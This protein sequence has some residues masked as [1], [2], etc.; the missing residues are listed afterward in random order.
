MKKTLIAFVFIF[1]FLLYFFTARL[2]A[3]S[4]V[5]LQNSEPNISLDFQDVGLKDALKVFSMQSGLNFIASEGVQERKITLYL[6]NVP[7]KKA[8]D[9]LFKANNLSYDLDTDSNIFIVKDWGKLTTETVTRVFYL[10][11]ATVSS[12]SLKEEMYNQ[13]NKSTDFST[14]SSSSSSS[15]STSSTGGSGKW[16]V[17]ENSGITEAIKKLLSASGSVIEDFRTNSLIVTDTPD[18]MAVVEKV[19]ASL[20]IIVPQV[21]LE[22]EMLDVSKNVVDQLGFDFGS[23][24][25]T[26]IVTGATASMGF[27]YAGLSKIFNTGDGQLSI[28]P[29]GTGGSPYSVTLDYLRTQ[30]DTKFLARPKLFTLNNE[31]AEIRI[32]SN[33]SIGIKTTVTSATSTTSAEAERTQTGIILRVTPQ[34]NMDTGEITMFV[35]PKVAEAVAGNTL[36][37]GSEDF[38]FRDPEERSTKSIVRVKDGETVVLGG[39]I[40]NEITA[41]SS[42]LP[43]LGDIPIIGM[44]FRHKGGSADKNKQRELLVFITPHIVKDKPEAKLAKIKNIE[45]P[46]REQNAVNHSNRDYLI[47]SSL[48]NFDKKR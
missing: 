8:M 14:D 1:Y 41:N 39:L 48:N 38:A 32:A 7:L 33:E 25:F 42:K 36:T 34:I 21:L 31:T 5:L 6:D 30:T 28:N 24:P 44:F 47:K 3:E 40:R 20:D 19:I 15:S 27:P 26:A 10:K 16:K 46:L 23:S 12:S 45:L 29:G 9:K 37:S 18:R 35:Y 13:M 2:F 4:G 11:Y 22:V 17:E 43:I